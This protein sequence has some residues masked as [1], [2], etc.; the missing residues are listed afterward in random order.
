MATV[1]SASLIKPEVFE[2]CE[3]TDESPGRIRRRAKIHGSSARLA[4][5][6]L[7][8]RIVTTVFLEQI[9]FAQLTIDVGFDDSSTGKTRGIG[10]D[11]IIQPPRCF[12]P[13]RI[14]GLIIGYQK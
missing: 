8:S 1:R 14:Y 13:T 10:P 6:I 4:A 2:I 3:R 7:S 5:T 9:L 12:P 11:R